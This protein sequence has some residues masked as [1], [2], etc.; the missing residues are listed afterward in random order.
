MPDTPTERA[1][2]RGAKRSSRKPPQTPGVTKRH[3]SNRGHSGRQMKPDGDPSNLDTKKKNSAI[4]T[5]SKRPD[6]QK[7]PET[8]DASNVQRKRVPP[9]ASSRKP[10][11]TEQRRTRVRVKNARHVQHGK[12]AVKV[13]KST[14]S[15]SA[16]TERKGLKLHFPRSFV[17]SVLG[18]GR[19][20]DD[21]SEVGGGRKRTQPDDS[22]PESREGSTRRKRRKQGDE[23][24]TENVRP[25]T[26]AKELKEADRA[27]TD[28]TSEMMRLR[29]QVMQLS[30]ELEKEKA[31]NT[32]LKQANETLSV[33][34]A[35]RDVTFKELN[36]NP[37][38]AF[39]DIPDFPEAGQIELPDE[40]KRGCERIRPVELCE[41]LDGL[42]IRFSAFR[43]K[44]QTAT[45]MRKALDERIR[46]LKAEFD[47]NKLDIVTMEKAVVQDEM[48]IAKS[49]GKLYAMKINAGT[50]VQTRASKLVRNVVESC[51]EK[52][53][54]HSLGTK[55]FYAWEK[56][57]K[58]YREEQ[59]NK[60]ERKRAKPA[61][62]TS[63]ENQVEKSKISGSVRE[64]EQ[65]QI[66]ETEGNEPGGETP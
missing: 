66:D 3:E 4:C 65:E 63:G 42:R 16:T 11:R 22:P 51:R 18:E 39:I 49:L 45:N 10:I 27:Q 29:K 53:Q 28:S 56:E 58:K 6:L 46:M 35:E 43:E 33:S 59:I 44:V 31:R 9:K 5:S 38:K 19:T 21:V 52:S 30:R 40:S 14:V 60:M 15:P 50:L 37:S 25:E 64:Q 57:E 13:D 36:S 17:L 54:I 26:S 1:W 2:R 61:K 23:M 7:S 48:E 47:G 20:T 55:L 24:N 12:G 8:H 32:K 41:E 62:G 34:L